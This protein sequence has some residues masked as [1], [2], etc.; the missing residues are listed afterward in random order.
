MTA[1]IGTAPNQVPTNQHLGGAAYMDPKDIV[2]PAWR[3][4]SGTVTAVAGDWL[5]IDTTSA[6]ATIT[7]PASPSPNDR[8]PFGDYA[9]TWGSNKVTF[10]RNGSKVM[11]LSE[12]YDITTANLNG[13]M[14]YIDS[15]Q[16]WKHL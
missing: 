3:V 6:T 8:I 2:A 15:T 14:T 12:D 4:V 1:M 5:L 7:L 11:G 9:G 16:G 10:A 13:V